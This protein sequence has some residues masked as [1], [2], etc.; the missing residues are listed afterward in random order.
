MSV[1]EQVRPG[2]PSSPTGASTE[3]P[4]RTWLV[5]TLGATVAVAAFMLAVGQRGPHQLAVPVP[6]PAHLVDGTPRAHHPLWGV[7]YWPQIFEIASILLAGTLI[8]TFARLSWKERR[9]H[10]GLAVTYAATGMYLFDPIFNW[11]WYFPTDPRFLHWPINWPYVSINP[12]SE[13]MTFMP[14]YTFWLM[15]PA[16]ITYGLW[17]GVQRRSRPGGFTQRHPVISLFLLG[18]AV[19]IPF[20][21]AGFTLGC[22]TEVFVFTQTHGPT[23]RAGHTS[24]HPLWEPL[25]FPLLI[26]ATCVLFCWRDDR[27]NTAAGRL[28]RRLP[29]FPRVPRLTEVVAAWAILAAVYGSVLGTSTLVFRIFTTP[30]TLAR[31]WPYPD[32]K[33]WDPDGL[34]RKAGEPGP[35]RAGTLNW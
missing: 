11:S 29:T 12:T 5:V 20:D 4:S 7:Q 32:T 24:Q 28:A 16:V 6:H 8:A 21:F 9:L 33:V 27:G 18:S 34:Y 30:H 19:A 10:P 14:A 2:R 17:R 1:L 22:V 26:T 15:I 3:E 35:Y 25:L 31:P 13:P 23:F